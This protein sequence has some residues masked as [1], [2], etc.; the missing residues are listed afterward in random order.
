MEG[1]SSQIEGG[2][3]LLVAVRLAVGALLLY[4][5]GN[6]LVRASRGCG[7]GAGLGLGLQQGTQ[8]NR[9]RSQQG[10]CHLEHR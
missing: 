8:K 6:W 9:N 4:S 5:D 10:L 1:D 3:L 2:A 7:E